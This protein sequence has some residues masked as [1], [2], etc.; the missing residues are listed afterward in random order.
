MNRNASVF[1]VENLQEWIASIATTFPF[2]HHGAR[3]MAIS[4]LSDVQEL[5]EYGE[6]ED[7]RQ[8]INRIKFMLDFFTPRIELEYRIV[9]DLDAHLRRHDFQ[10]TNVSDGGE[11]HECEYIE[12]ALP[13]IFAVEE[14]TLYYRKNNKVFF[15]TIIPGNGEDII[16]DHSDPSPDTHGFATAMNSFRQPE[17]MR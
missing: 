4:L 2:R 16:A 5:I 9:A 12:E 10:I 17:E 13:H 7:A 6:N 3:F 8:L 14:A 11:S 1:G 15:I